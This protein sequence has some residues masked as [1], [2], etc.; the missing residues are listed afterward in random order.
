MDG[1]TTHWELRKG[2]EVLGTLVSYSWDF[3][4]LDCDFEPTEAFDHYRDLFVGEFRLL[5]AP[6]S[7]IEDSEW[8][9]A[10]DR[11]VAS[12]IAFVPVTSMAQ[13]LRVDL[14]RSMGDLSDWLRPI[15][16]E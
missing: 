2:D 15:L 7:Q 14:I 4:W 16:G 1:D 12:G 5:K 3:P 9:D 6:E 10:Y 13:A 8:E 11:I